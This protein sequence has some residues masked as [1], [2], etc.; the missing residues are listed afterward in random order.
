MGESPGVVAG[1]VVCVTAGP[2]DLPGVG[3]PPIGGRPLGPPVIGKVNPGGAFPGRRGPRPA[4]SGVG[5]GDESVPVVAGG[6][7]V[8]CGAT[9]GLAGVFDATE[10]CPFGDPPVAGGVVDSEPP[11]HPATIKAT[12]ETAARHENQGRRDALCVMGMLR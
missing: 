8:V 2:V 12:I 11:P 5:S 7:E 3:V 1:G 10:G 6:V 4:V 9:A